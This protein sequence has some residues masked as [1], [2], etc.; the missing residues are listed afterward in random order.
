MGGRFICRGSV[1]PAVDVRV[2]FFAAYRQLTGK[3]EASVDVPPNATLGTLLDRVL[4]AHPE[5]AP[6]RDTMLFAVNQEFAGPDAKLH[7]GDEV[8]LLPPVSGGGA[9]CWI[10][11]DPINPM[12]V[13]DRVRSVGAGAV[14][15]FLGTVRADP[16]VRALDYEAYDAMAVKQMESLRSAAKGRFAVSEVA[17]AHRTGVLPLGEASVAIACSAPHREA[18][19]RACE[20][21]IEELKRIV[22]IWKTVTEA[23]PGP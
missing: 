7:G 1:L 5:L 21:A 19:F 12:A 8:A 18:A 10:Q 11:T 9:M 6:H 20:W 14:V 15:L 17:I 4:R 2:R 23:D 13:V 22:P 16:G 3:S